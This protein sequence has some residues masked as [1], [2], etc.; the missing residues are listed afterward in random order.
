MTRTEDTG[1]CCTP[2]RADGAPGEVAPRPQPAPGAA[3]RPLADA[4]SDPGARM[5]ALA[6]GTF[7]MGSNDRGA[8]PLDGE[9]PVREITVSPFRIDTVAVSNER[10][11]RF[12]EATGYETESERFGWSFVFVGFLPQDHPPTRSVPQA[13]WWRQVFGAT[14]HSPEGPGSGID[15]RLDHPVVHVSHNDALAYCAWAGARLPTEAE[16]EFAARGG[17]DGKMFP[18]GDELMP[19]GEHQCNIWQ[20]TFPEENTAED[21]YRGTA[22]VTAYQPNGFGLYN[23]IGNA[24]EW[25]ADW[26]H[27]R[28]HA[29]QAAPRVDPRGPP[30]GTARVMKGGSH[31]CHRSY[32]Y[33]Y[34][35]G[36]RSSSPPDSGSGNVGFRIAMDRAIDNDGGIR[37]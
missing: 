9:G 35:V 34:R 2:A 11:R 24:W 7:R 23:T 29:N 3:V 37:T 26:F 12:V 28:F 15:E 31:L 4:P 32:C 25:C 13:P 21:G 1:R 20:G 5:V 19:E 18:W 8:H 22:P 33:R 27:N 6:G 14:W 30:H 36:A 10:F 16:W 17:L